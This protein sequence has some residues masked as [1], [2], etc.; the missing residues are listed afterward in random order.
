M[1]PFKR[2]PSAPPSVPPTAAPAREAEITHALESIRPDGSSDRPIALADVTGVLEL[3]LERVRLEV[4]R[5]HATLSCATNRLMH[6]T[7]AMRATTRRLTD[8]P[9]DPR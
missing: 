9:K 3:A 7:R 1:N 5:T 4:E 8:P 6:E 2:T